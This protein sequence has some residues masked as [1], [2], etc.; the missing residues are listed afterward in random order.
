[1]EGVAHPQPLRLAS[2]WNGVEFRGME[3]TQA[4]GIHACDRQALANQK[5]DAVKSLQSGRES[6]M[7]PG[8]GRFDGRRGRT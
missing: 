6:S 7:G 5:W 4:R 1:M 8:A 3:L 2:D